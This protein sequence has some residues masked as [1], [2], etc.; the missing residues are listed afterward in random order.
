M[1]SR[2]RGKTICPDCKGTRLRK[3]ANYV[4]ISDK[5]IRD[6][7]LMPVDQLA[8]F[9]HTLSLNEFET[10]VAKRLL[11]EINNRLGVLNDVGLGYI[12]L[13]RLSSSLSGGESQRINLSTALGSNL[14]GSMYIL[15]EPSIGLHPRDTQR[16]IKVL[17]RL[18]DL[19]NSVIVVEHDEEI[20]RAADQIIDIG[21]MAG[22]WGGEVIFQGDFRDLHGDSRSLTAQYLNH[23]R[24]IEVPATRRK[25]QEYIEIR[26]ARENN[27]K[28]IDVKIPLHVFTVVTGVSGSGKTSLI[29]RILVPSLKKLLGGYGEK[30]GKFDGLEGD[31]K[32]IGGVEMVDQNPIGRS[33]RSNP[34]TYIKAFDEIRDLYADQQLSRVR[35]YKPGYFSFNIEG[36]RCDECE[37][38]GVVKIEMQFM[39]DLFLPC[40]ACQG[41]RF[42]DEV[43]DVKYR[44]KS[45]VDILN[46]TVDEAMAFFQ[47]A[48]KPGVHEKH[49][50]NRLKPLQDV[51]LGYLR[52]GQSSNTLSGGEAQRIKLA[53]FLTKGTSEH[54]NLF[55][56]DEPTTGLHIHD[57]K[58][59][60]ESFESLISYGHS[61]VVIE[62]N[63]DVI[64][65]AD[66]VI[67]LGTEGG[68]QGGHLV[69]EG[70][71]EELVKVENSY[72]GFYLREK[73]NV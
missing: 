51:G 1:M 45:I 34:A 25:W 33:S 54:P 27:L 31:F 16:L 26:G 6:L 37:G 53:F 56:F 36:G 23:V 41:K 24:S 48:V 73:L 28:Y 62:H 70:V 38:E 47:D 18:R 30:T 13:N 72:T 71:P 22:A 17:L 44:D 35:G 14:V 40:E 65:C 49:I 66:W 68:D 64:K 58:K 61:I 21:P 3:D 10:T 15:D 43:L 20:I 5:S 9:C 59:L 67:D 4:K 52:L 42:K 55:I 32:K 57:I 8:E 19:G 46:M 50:L 12:T 11:L 7:V 2:Y 63:P 60:L 29:R 69:F 39:A